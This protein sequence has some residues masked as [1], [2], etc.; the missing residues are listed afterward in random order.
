M[1]DNLEDEM[2]GL[3]GK[4][5]PLAGFQMGE[6][7]TQALWG[8][9]ATTTRA[10]GNV[11]LKIDTNSNRIFVAITLRW[12]ARSSRFDFFHRSWLARAER[13]CQGQMPSGWKLLVY[14]ERGYGRKN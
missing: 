10:F 4:S 2:N 7:L 3:A 5:D 12:W 11:S 8:A 14:Y 6:A 13:R 9:A 1:R